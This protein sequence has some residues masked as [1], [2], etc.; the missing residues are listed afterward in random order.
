MRSIKPLATKSKIYENEFFVFDVETWGLDARS[1]KLAFGVVYG[2][3]FIKVL[4]TPEQFQ[5][6]FKKEIYRGK[7]IFAHNAE[8]DLS[9]IFGNVIQNVDSSAIFN[10]KFIATKYFKTNFV[11]SANLYPSTLEKIGEAMGFEKGV[12]P[13]KFINADSSKKITD[14]DIDYCIKDCKITFEI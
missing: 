10:G 3:N 12:T 7:N 1:K 14:Q 5:N 4:H 8:F 13:E 9:V 2:N 11:D 6:E